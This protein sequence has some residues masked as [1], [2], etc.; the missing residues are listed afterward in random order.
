MSLFCHG[1][2]KPLQV[3]EGHARNKLR[4]PECGVI[5][6]V[7]ASARQAPAPKART[8]AAAAAPE[9]L[10]LFEDSP[11]PVRT[12]R[13]PPP[14]A[15]A[16]APAPRKKG[17]FTCPHCGELVKL[18]GLKR[19]GEAKCPNCAGII[20][21]PSKDEGAAVPEMPPEP[22]TPPT[23]EPEL[24]GTDED[25]GKPYLVPRRSE[26]TCPNCSRGLPKDAEVCDL[27]GFTQPGATKQTEFDKVNV[28]WEGG[29]K[30]SARW[31]LFLAAQGFF[32]F[33]SALA[34]LLGGAEIVVLLCSW[35]VFSGLVSFLLGTFDRIDLSRNK[36][37]QVLLTKTWRICFLQQPVTR[38]YLRDYEGISTGR[39][40]DSGCL[41]WFLF[42]IWLVMG[43]FPAI[44]GVMWSF[45][46]PSIVFCLVMG[47]I[48]AVL[49]W[50]Y[51]IHHDKFYVALNREHGFPDV[52]L[53][54]GLN[55]D[56]TVEIAEKLEEVTGLTYERGSAG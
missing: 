34:M 3:P 42:G 38:L 8:P 41:D 23:P 6:E 43:I 32:L 37:G 44:L 11:P 33:A 17:L 12:E 36:S 27:C 53:Y 26:L 15:A 55:Q 50:Y 30:L 22:K 49:W 9:E 35:L 21:W 46:I 47:I 4:C 18:P 31:S 14:P 20:T 25:D 48:P 13:Q 24:D 54:R 28:S 29:L 7:P 52:I 45:S 19:G 2:G 39:T 40:H 56:L 16:P 5:C 1:C 51:A 10:L